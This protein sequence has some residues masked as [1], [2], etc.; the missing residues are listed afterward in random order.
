[1][2]RDEEMTP[3]RMFVLFVVYTILGCTITMR[4]DH[5]VGQLFYLDSYVAEV[6]TP[7]Y[8]DDYTKNLLVEF[9]NMSTGKEA[10][11]FKDDHILVERKIHIVEVDN[12]QQVHLVNPGDETIAVTHNGNGRCLIELGKH[13]DYQTYRHVLFHEY[14]HCFGYPDLYE[15]RYEKDLMYYLEGPVD[16]NIIKWYSEDISVKVHKWKNLRNLNLN[17]EQTK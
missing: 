10:V 8:G 2:I 4:V 12:V 14:C 13:M 5:P 16:D 6:N 3:L 11:S 15:K 17:T 9:N 7:T 1:M